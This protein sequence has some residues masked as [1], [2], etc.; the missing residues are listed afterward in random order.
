MKR[1][2]NPFQPQ[3]KICLTDE[4]TQSFTFKETQGKHGGD[5]VSREKTA[6]RRNFRQ[7]AIKARDAAFQPTAPQSQSENPDS[8]QLPADRNYFCVRSTM[9]VSV[10]GRE[11]GRRGEGGRG[12]YLSYGTKSSQLFFNDPKKRYLNGVSFFCH[13]DVRQLE[14]IVGM[15]ADTP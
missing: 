6:E 8:S 4:G 7:Q 1:S 9:Q 14:V 10:G 11:E 13:S 5:R 12:S 2:H 3:A 15:A